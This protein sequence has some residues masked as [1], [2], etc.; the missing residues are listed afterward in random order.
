MYTHVTK[1]SVHCNC[2][3]Q[4]VVHSYRFFHL[5]YYSGNRI[6]NVVTCHSEDGDTIVT[7]HSKDF[8]SHKIFGLRMKYIKCTIYGRK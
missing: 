1:L 2:C 6:R 4:V 7:A 8:I 5:A 3:I